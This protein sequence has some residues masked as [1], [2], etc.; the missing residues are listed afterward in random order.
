MSRQNFFK[1][2][3]I[4]LGLLVLMSFSTNLSATIYGNGS[5]T[6]YEPP[7]PPPPDGGSGNAIP[8]PGGPGMEIAYESST[9]GSG[10]ES[11]NYYL[12]SASIH[13]FESYSHFK[14][15]L[16]Y[17]EAAELDGPNYGRLKEKIKNTVD[18]MKKIIEFQKQLIMIAE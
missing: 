5:N 1:I 13:F 2:I 10:T 11:I 18:E 15:F 3:G 7:P 8:G 4:V 17:I 12:V 9:Q 16:S 14:S 6:A